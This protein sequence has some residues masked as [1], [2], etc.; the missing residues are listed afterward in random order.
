MQNLIQ[1]CR[2]DDGPAWGE[3]WLMYDH[4]AAQPIRRL[5]ARAGFNPTEADVVAAES[6]ESLWEDGFKRLRSF[7]GTTESELN[8]WLVHMAV[9]FTRNWI[10]ERCRTQ[11]REGSGIR[12][13]P[14]PERDAATEEKINSLLDDLESVRSHDDVN[15]LRSQVGLETESSPESTKPASER[16]LRRR[17]QYLERMVREFLG[18]PPR[19]K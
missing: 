6:F 12:E 3:L 4:I 17:F 14:E 15:R 5:L 8:N 7:H 1:Q 16:T 18:L 11:K 2:A 9:N 19:R 10:K 13:I